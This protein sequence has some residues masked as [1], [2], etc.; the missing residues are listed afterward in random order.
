MRRSASEVIRNLEVRIAQLEKSAS[1]K[2]KIRILSH[3]NLDIGG[4][5]EMVDLKG[6]LGLMKN[7]ESSM[8]EEIETY[9]TSNPQDEFR[10]NTKFYQVQYDSSDDVVRLYNGTHTK[11]LELFSYTI[12]IRDASKFAFALMGA[13]PLFKGMEV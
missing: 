8:R 11:E 12:E 10:S 5:T 3:H 2:F 4:S 6:L 13:H 1:V 7:L 9:L